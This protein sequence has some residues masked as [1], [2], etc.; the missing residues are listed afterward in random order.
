M[1][2]LKKEWSELPT[3]DKVFYPGLFVTC[4]VLSFGL[5][6]VLHIVGGGM[7]EESGGN[8]YHGAVFTVVLVSSL[9]AATLFTKKN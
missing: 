3:L 8:Y 6:T 9:F 5:G 2:E 1:R 7:F 4:Y